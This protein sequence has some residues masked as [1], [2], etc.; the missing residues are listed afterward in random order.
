MEM[1]TLASQNALTKQILALLRDNSGRSYTMKELAEAQ[2][3][4]G[5]TPQITKGIELLL[6]Q[7]LIRV[8]SRGSE[9]CYQ[10]VPADKK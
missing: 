10:I 8:K 7:G 3:L 9:L 1:D 6:K 5:P 4:F 2:H